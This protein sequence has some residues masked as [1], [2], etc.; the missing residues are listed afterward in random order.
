MGKRAKNRD[1]LLPGTLDML[2][3]KTLSI[4]VMHGY[5]IAQH[6]RQVS[7]EILQVEEGSLYPA[8]QRLQIQGLVQSEWGHSAN[9]RRARYYRLTRAGRRALGEASSTFDRLV[10]AITRVM[11]PA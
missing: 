11:R 4:G 7:D 10:A 3:L 8:L 9:N 1:D 6:I 5:G 2:I